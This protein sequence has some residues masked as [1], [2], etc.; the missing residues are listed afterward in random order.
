MV[1]GRMPN[2]NTALIERIFGK[3]GGGFAPVDARLYLE[4]MAD[5][6][7]Y[8]ILGTT[9]LSGVFRGRD[10]IVDRIFRPLMER[11]DGGIE[12]APDTLFGEGDVVGMQAHG[13]ARTKKGARYDNT[14]CFVFRFRDGR[15][16]EIAEY[17]DTELVQSALA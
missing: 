15:I 7:R 16:T 6:V 8:M 5:D 1:C 9:P 17:L 2:A 14:Y 4:S 12:L 10:Q 13:R 3:V 11:L